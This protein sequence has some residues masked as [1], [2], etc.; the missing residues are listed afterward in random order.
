LLRRLLPFELI[1]E[2]E[3]SGITVQ[4]KIAPEVNNFIIQILVFLAYVGSSFVK[5]LK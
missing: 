5:T 2:S 1:I 4:L 3:T